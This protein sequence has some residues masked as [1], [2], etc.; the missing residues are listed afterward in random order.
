MVL[1]EP[2]TEHAVAEV[3]TVNNNS[4]HGSELAPSM[5]QRVVGRKSSR[6]SAQGTKGN[7]VREINLKKEFEDKSPR[8]TQPSRNS[9]I[10]NGLE[11]IQTL[12][13]EELKSYLQQSR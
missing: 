1:D 5:V 10:K 2:P 12:D 9:A 4:P 7:D 13:K 6:E 3:M 11:L 8:K